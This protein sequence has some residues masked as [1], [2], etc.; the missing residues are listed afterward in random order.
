MKP[1]R[2]AQP[3]PNSKR[4]L[5]GRPDT[6][7]CPTSRLRPKP[8]AMHEMEASRQRFPQCSCGNTFLA[9]YVRTFIY[10]SSSK[11][12]SG[13]ELRGISRLGQLG[14]RPG[15]PAFTVLEVNGTSES[16][17]QPIDLSPLCYT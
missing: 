5:R 9:G 2:R 15:C 6:K 10:I 14:G 16:T 13:R 12:I 17:A 7:A 3:S 11:G 8:C 1:S 4:R